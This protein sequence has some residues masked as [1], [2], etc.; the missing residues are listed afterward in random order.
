[1]PIYAWFLWKAVKCIICIERRRQQ[2]RREP[3]QTA[4]CLNLF[5]YTNNM[6]S[7]WFEKPQ[8]KGEREKPFRRAK[9]IC[10]F[11]KENKSVRE[12]NEGE[13]KSE[14]TTTSTWMAPDELY[15]RSTVSRC[16]ESQITRALK[17]FIVAKCRYS[18]HHQFWWNRFDGHRQFF[19]CSPSSSSS[20]VA[21]YSLRFFKNSYLMC[22]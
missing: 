3:R 16:C 17:E 15:E 22:L 13:K 21:S 2:R 20:S 19:C 6:Y 5:D 14:I 4:R 18:S 1:M 10:F 8:T 11:K 9:K 12:K 7:E